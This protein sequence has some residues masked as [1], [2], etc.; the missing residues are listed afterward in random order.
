MTPDGFAARLADVRA[1]IDAAARRAGRDPAGVTLLAVSKTFPLSSLREAV[2]AGVTCFGESRVQEALPKIAALGPGIAW[3]L[4]GHLQRNKAA[5]A[6]GA[7]ALIHSLDS[8]R[9]AERLEQEAAER[10]L[11]QDVLV[12]VNPAG[13]PH[14]YG[15]APGD[16]EALC[17]A[18][19][20]MPHLNVRGL[21][22]MAPYDPDPEKARPH[23]AALTALADGIAQKG[24]RGVTM[25]VR[26]MGMSG[27]FEVAVEEGATLVRVGSALFG[28]R[29]AR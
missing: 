26:S 20:A 3:H 7:F 2:A 5:R 4:V 14:K 10:G 6:V 16:A 19:G 28:A 27:D 23:F 12:E 9:L 11:V 21:M 13:D 1:R 22:G 15:V 25:E 17:R 29:E 24:P 8:L 18:A